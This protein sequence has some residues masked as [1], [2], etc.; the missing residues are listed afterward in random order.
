MGPIGAV[1][2]HVIIAPGDAYPFVVRVS[3]RA[4][5]RRRRVDLEFCM[6][7]LR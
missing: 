3:D 6:R 7:V 5:R 2:E 1:R 4:R